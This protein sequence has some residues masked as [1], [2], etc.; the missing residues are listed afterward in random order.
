ML[1]NYFVASVTIE[2]AP[3][4]LLLTG[5]CVL[6]S[7]QN[8]HKELLNRVDPGPPVSRTGQSSQGSLHSADACSS[9]LQDLQA[10]AADP[11][12]TLQQ[13]QARLGALRLRKQRITGDGGEVHHC[14]WLG[15]TVSWA[16]LRGAA[17]FGKA[18]CDV[19]LYTCS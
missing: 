15:F 13:M 14:T 9:E 12:G 11:T 4:N 10:A 7:L 2:Q 16:K 1:I 8:E 17:G 6:C 3:Q 5:I 19:C 18:A